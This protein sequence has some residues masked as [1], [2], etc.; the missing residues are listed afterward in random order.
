[1]RGSN[2]KKFVDSYN[3]LAQPCGTTLS[4]LARKLGVEE[5]QARRAMETVEDILKCS[6]LKDKAI[7]G[8]EIRYYLDR[9][10]SKRLSEI[11]LADLNLT[12]GEIIAL[13][14]LKS[15]AK[16]YAGTGIDIEIER[17]FAKMDAFVPA[18]FG[19]QLDKVK[20]IFLSSSKF[21]KNYAAKQ[22]IID[23]L[24]DATLKQQTCLVE[25]HSFSDDTVK[26]YNIDP[27]KFFEQ[28]GGLYFF[29]RT[30]SYGD[31]RILAVERI[32]ALTNTGIPFD[33]PE[34]FKPDELLDEAFGLNYDDPITVKIR[35]SADQAKYIEE[36]RWAKKQ[37]ITKR[38]DGSIVLT[39]ETSGWWDVKK[40]VLSFG[41]EAEVME[42]VEMRD[43]I[44][45]TMLKA[46]S[47]YCKK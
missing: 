28:N 12:V 2:L 10:Q 36:R 25:Y 5:R 41:A 34:D 20:T 1:M 22:A 7:L 37:R 21:A 46:I 33:Y 13:H 15:H 39:M 3:L 27:L 35:F 47:I 9:E 8:G 32:N 45:A 16:L 29:V 43:E 17:A 26:S 11:K 30:T 38:K 42:P 40:W 44:K 24:T 19:K 18:G 31:I 23:Q 14:F 6:V 4:E